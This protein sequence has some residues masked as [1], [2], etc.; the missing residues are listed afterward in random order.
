VL[1]DGGATA[2]ASRTPA[3][4]LRQAATRAFMPALV[5][6]AAFTVDSQRIFGRRVGA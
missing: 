3:S 6:G 4:Q 2:E 5:G 1:I